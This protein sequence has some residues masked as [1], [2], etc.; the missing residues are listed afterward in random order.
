MDLVFGFIGLVVLFCVLYAAFLLA[1]S[2]ID[3]GVRKAK[4]G[5]KQTQE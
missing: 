3:F 1:K 5:G 4:L 2:I